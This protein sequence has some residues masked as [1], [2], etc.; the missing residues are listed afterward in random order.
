MTDADANI[1]EVSLCPV[2]DLQ[3]AE[4]L[5][6]ELM[7][8]RGRPLQVD[9]SQV[10]RIGGLCLQVLLSARMTWAEDGLPLRVE[11]ASDGFLEQLAAFG[12]PQI[13]FEPEG[14]HL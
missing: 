13:N 2:L 9:A 7:A 1:A 4:P 3:A 14:A 5:R 6:A 12:G 10:S 8:L 11:Q